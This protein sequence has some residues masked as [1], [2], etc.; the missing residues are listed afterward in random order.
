MHNARNVFSMSFVCVTW[1]KYFTSTP[2]DSAYRCTICDVTLCLSPSECMSNMVARR[3]QKHR[4]S[5]LSFG[6]R[7][8]TC[9]SRQR[10]RS[11]RYC[12]TFSIWATT[13][14][15]CSAIYVCT[16]MFYSHVRE[17]YICSNEYCR[18]GGHTKNC[19]LCASALNSAT[20]VEPSSSS[21]FRT[22]LRSNTTES[23]ADT[24]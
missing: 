21:I 19:P 18:N 11:L 2:S 15:S 10:G 4:D 20:F 9:V 17:M 8:G 16:G 3:S 24:K 13:R 22:L 7:G 12:I 14:K 6:S 5:C 1:E 23:M